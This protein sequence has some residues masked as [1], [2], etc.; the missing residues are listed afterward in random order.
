MLRKGYTPT[1]Y[2]RKNQGGPH[3]QLSQRAE[4]A[5]RYL[6]EVQWGQGTTTMQGDPR[7]PKVITTQVPVREDEI[8]TE[9]LD[10]AIKRLKNR[11]SGGPDGT[12]IEMF[13]AME[14]EAR[15]EVRTILNKWWIEEKIEPEALRARVVHLYKK[16]NTSDMANYRPIS[17]LNTNV[18]TVCSHSADQTSQRD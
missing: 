7:G 6:S 3:I 17:L 15:E 9:E 10:K 1:P 8:S 16:G 13:K 11:K 12:A 4:E 2:H 5:A 14:A 18:Q